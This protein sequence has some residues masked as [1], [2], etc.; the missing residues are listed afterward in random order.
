MEHD[1]A[2]WL[3]KGLTKIVPQAFK[4]DIEENVYKLVNGNNQLLCMNL[5]ILIIF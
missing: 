3:L 1:F 5:K 2:T 4:R